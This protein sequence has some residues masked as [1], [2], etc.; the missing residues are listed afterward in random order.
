MHLNLYF[1]FSLS[2]RQREVGGQHTQWT[3]IVTARSCPS[4]VTRKLNQIHSGVKIFNCPGVKV[5]LIYWFEEC[6]SCKLNTA[7]NEKK[8]LK[9][10]SLI[11]CLYLLSSPHVCPSQLMKKGTAQVSKNPPPPAKPE[12]TKS[13]GFRNTLRSLRDKLRTDQKSLV[14]VEQ[15][16]LLHCHTLKHSSSLLFSAN[17]HLSLFSPALL[18]GRSLQRSRPQKTFGTQ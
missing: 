5:I 13:R 16:L 15:Q 7:I 3:A 14:R 11:S 10:K 4:K 6:P 9:N 1:L 18:L 8:R 12:K 17:L 2:V